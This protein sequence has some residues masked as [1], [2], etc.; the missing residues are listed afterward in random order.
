MRKKIIVL[1]TSFFLFAVSNTYNVGALDTEVL[2]SK[3]YHIID[4]I[5]NRYDSELLIYN[6]SEFMNSEIASNY[7]FDYKNYLEKILNTDLEKFENECIKIVTYKISDFEVDI[8]MDSMSVLSTKTVKF[9]SSR[10]SMTLTYKH[11]GTKFDT[12]YKPTVKVNKL[13][14]TYY[15]VMSSYTGSFKNYNKSY[16]VNAK[17]KIYTSFGV[18]N[19][20]SFTV[21]FNL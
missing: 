19:N 4:W 7:D 11:N 21:N 1:L 5:N 13:S 14:S 2:L 6:E 16:S 18:S 8:K 10:N 15:F 3:Y 12:S 9:N 20:K 17:G